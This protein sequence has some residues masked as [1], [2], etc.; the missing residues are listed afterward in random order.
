L[1]IA[2]PVAPKDIADKVNKVTDTVVVLY[3]PSSFEAVGQF[4]H[5][6]SQVSD[7]QVKEIMHKHGYKTS[8]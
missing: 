6:F 8:F 3:S 5:D 1:I 4:Y 2:V 7:N